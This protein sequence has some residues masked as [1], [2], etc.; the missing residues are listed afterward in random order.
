M[1]RRV[2]INASGAAKIVMADRA[3]EYVAYDKLP[4]WARE[5]L[6][7]Y[8]YPMNC[9]EFLD[10]Y[11]QMGDRLQECA[12]DV[13]TGLRDRELRTAWPPGHPMIGKPLKKDWT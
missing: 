7:Q 5:L 8:A 6:Q 2:N 3:G 11:N 9:Q 4:R 1:D 10:A 12:R 13:L